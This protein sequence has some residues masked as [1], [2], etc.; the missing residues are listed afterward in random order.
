ML[1]DAVQQ[2]PVQ[3]DLVVDLCDDAALSQGYLGAA[4][5]YTERFDTKAWA[6]RG[7]FTHAVVLCSTWHSSAVHGIGKP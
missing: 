2:Y 6:L 4:V 3:D 7:T 1:S 5:V